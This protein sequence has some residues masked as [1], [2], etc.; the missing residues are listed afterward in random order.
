MGILWS[1]SPTPGTGPAPAYVAVPACGCCM[2]GLGFGCCTAPLP[3][4]SGKI[5]ICYAHTLHCV[6]CEGKDWES[7]TNQVPLPYSPSAQG[8]TLHVFPHFIHWGAPAHLPGPR[9]YPGALQPLY[10]LGLDLSPGR[11]GSMAGRG[12]RGLSGSLYLSAH[13]EP[14]AVPEF[15]S[16]A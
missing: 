9:L 4:P 10:L 12:W 15:T 8:Y 6:F 13:P 3:V 14:H 2:F 7:R 16:Q 11:P 1:Q 5:K